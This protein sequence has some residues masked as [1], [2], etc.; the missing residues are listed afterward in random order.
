A[1]CM[2]P[3]ERTTIDVAR[4]SARQRVGVV[5]ISDSSVSPLARIARETIIVTS[6]SQSFFRSLAPAF[7]AVEILAALTAAQSE[8]D[9]ADR[10]K[11]SEE[12]LAAFG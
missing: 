4:Q 10:I 5:A 12:Q 9:A 2:S 1:L 6:N 3:Y 11:Q 8:V 7:A